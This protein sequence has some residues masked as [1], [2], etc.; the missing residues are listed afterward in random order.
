MPRNYDKGCRSKT[1]KK[2]NPTDLA[3]AVNA[4]K[5][6]RMTYREAQEVYGIHYSVI[7][8]HVKNKE[9]KKQGGQTSLS[10]SEEKLLID[11]ILLC[12]EWG[13]PL[14]RL[15]LRLL[16]KGYLNRRGKKV[17]RFGRSNMPGKEWV[18]SFLTRHSDV[19][20]V[21]LC[22]N[23][24]RCRAAV[25]RETINQYFD[26]LTI[27]LE[28]IPLSHIINY[29]ETNL[30]D[31]P[32]RRKIITKR[33][34]RYPERIINSTKTSISIMFAACADGTL[35]PL[36]TVYKSKHLHESW[37][38][39]GPKGARFNRSP[40]G[41]FDSLCFDDWI[42][43]IALPYFSKLSG[44]KVLIGDNLSSHLSTDSIK[45]CKENNIRF[46]FLPNN[47]THLT[48]PLDVAFFRPLKIHWRNILEQWKKTEGKDEC[49]LPKDR[50]PR[51]LK[52]LWLKIQE[53]GSENIVAGFNKCGIAPL[54]RQRVL[55][56]L[57]SDDVDKTDPNIEAA[58]STI[59]KDFLKEMRPSDQTK[60][61]QTRKRLNVQPGRSVETVS[62]EEEINELNTSST[63]DSN[64]SSDN[65]ETN[66]N[67]NN[68]STEVYVVK[69]EK[70]FKNV[71]PIQ[72][73]KDVIEDDWYLVGFNST[74][75]KP[76]TSKVHY[77]YFIGQIIKKTNGG[78]LGTF[79]R[80]KN[81][82]DFNG[83]IYCFP[84][85]KDEFEFQFEQIIGKLD[86]PTPY[87]RGLLK[88]KLDFKSL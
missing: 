74:S 52:L 65:I 2:T 46:V 14:D 77:T 38:I 80:K 70:V 75:N 54:N 55:D 13:F 11:N 58:L 9:I 60:K 56:M 16:V 29:D 71:H 76:S 31:D 22:Q 39:G 57:P 6:K 18:N 7:Y 59:L 49:S 8:R 36:Y 30:T 34:T 44:Q 82:R 66:I 86:S 12:A 68:G 19:L 1:Y 20:A 62:S 10:L 48:Q 5:R 3:N 41:W 35:L 83:Y 84:N 50:F 27:S 25:S 28:G 88:F 51:L 53:N 87:N 63:S 43:S 24:K 33:G 23:I 42:K 73:N 26:N 47:S 45:L 67:Q 40:S 78:Y 61:R 21:R 81:T 15:D 64:I 72:H 37:R 79:L 4:I 32:A 69:N 17:K 85:V